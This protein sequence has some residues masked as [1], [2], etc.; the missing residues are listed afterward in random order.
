MTDWQPFI[1]WHYVKGMGY[2]LLVCVAL[3][4]IVGIWQQQYEKDRS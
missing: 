1:T 2:V 4:W 3:A